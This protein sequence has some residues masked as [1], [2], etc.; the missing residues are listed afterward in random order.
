MGGNEN[1][2]INTP[3]SN[4]AHWNIYHLLD[5]DNLQNNDFIKREDGKKYIIS[6]SYNLNN[7]ILYCFFLEGEGQCALSLIR[8]S[9]CSNIETAKYNFL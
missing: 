6:I 2:I 3:I 9:Q 8:Q 1:R 7:H 5:S 4:R